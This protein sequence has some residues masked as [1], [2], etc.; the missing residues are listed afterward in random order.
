MFD[1]IIAIQS[2]SRSEAVKEAMRQFIIENTPEEYIPKQQRAMYKQ[3]VSDT[4]EGM[5]E[6]IAKMAT[7]PKFQNLQQQNNNPTPLP[8]ED[9]FRDPRSYKRAKRRQNKERK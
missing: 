2:Y 8:Q 4:F 3:S 7:N 6:G 1:E 5:G 9:P